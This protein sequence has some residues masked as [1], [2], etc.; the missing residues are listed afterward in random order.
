MIIESLNKIYTLIEIVHNAKPENMLL[1]EALDE[2]LT[3]VDCSIL[4]S[5][6]VATFEEY[7]LN[8]N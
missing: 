3:I 8:D 4:H 1:I 7:N 2:L 5:E 6:H